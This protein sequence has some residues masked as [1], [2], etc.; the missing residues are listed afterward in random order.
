[1]NR[2]RD[3]ALLHEPLSPAL[4]DR[5]PDRAAQAQVG[6]H[7]LAESALVFRAHGAEPLDDD[8]QA[9][10]QAL[11]VADEL[12]PFAL[13]RAIPLAPGPHPGAGEER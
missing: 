2:R 13:E 1:M 12:V 5:E 10:R 3:R 4:H 8:G 7:L 6:S 11:G 9:L